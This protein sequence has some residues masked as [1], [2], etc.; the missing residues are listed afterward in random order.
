MFSRPG[1]MIQAYLAN[2]NLR[3]TM[4]KCR[5]AYTSY[6]KLLVQLKSFLRGVEY[7]ENVLLSDIKTLDDIIIDQCPSINHFLKKYDKKFTE[8]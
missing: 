5:F 3:K 6:G 4:E 8:E 7:D 2:T 1:V